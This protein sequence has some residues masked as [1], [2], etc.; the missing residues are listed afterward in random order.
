MVNLRDLL[1]SFPG[2]A[3]RMTSFETN[4]EVKL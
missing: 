3:V 1:F 4:E 2:A